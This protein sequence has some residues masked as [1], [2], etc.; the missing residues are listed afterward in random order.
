MKNFQGF[1]ENLMSVSRAG[2][3]M[4]APVHMNVE[5]IILLP[6]DVF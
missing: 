1:D 2:A 4:G 5:F 6:T 3:H